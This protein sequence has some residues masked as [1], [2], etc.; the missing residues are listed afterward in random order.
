MLM[1]SQKD[2]PVHVWR[3]FVAARFAGLGRRRSRGREE[4]A[5]LA[6]FLLAVFLSAS[7]AVFVLLN[8]GSAACV[9]GDVIPCLAA[10]SAMITSL[11]SLSRRRELFPTAAIGASVLHVVRAVVTVVVTIHDGPIVHSDIIVVRCNDV[12]R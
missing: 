6:A 1:P 4:F 3:R 5:S 7:D 8:K 2:L 12:R 9:F 11:G 10:E